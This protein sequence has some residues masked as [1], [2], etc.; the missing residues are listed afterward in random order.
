MQE[1][2]ITYKF[3]FYRLEFTNLKENNVECALLTGKVYNSSSEFHFKKYLS[4]LKN[5][6]WK[7]QRLV[8][9]RK[10]P[11]SFDSIEFIQQLVDKAAPLL[12][13]INM[14]PGEQ[15]ETGARLTINQKI[16]P[17]DKKDDVAVS[18][19]SQILG[20]PSP[21]WDEIWPLI[22]N[23]VNHD[24]H[25]TVQGFTNE[26]II[27]AIEQLELVFPS[28]WVKKQFKLE[29]KKHN[30]VLSMGMDFPPESDFWY[31]AYHIGRTALGAICI[32]PG[33]NFLVE[34][35]L[36]INDLK[37]VSGIEKIKDSL[38]K[39]SGNQHCV[40]LANDLNQRGLL[41]ELEPLIGN[42]PYKNDIT[43]D[44]NS[45]IIDIESKAFT[46]NNPDK[47]LAKEINKKIECL[48]N[49]YDRTLVFYAVLI[50]NGVFDKEKEIVF[51]KSISKLPEL[52]D[53]ITAVIGGKLFVDASGGHLKRDSEEIFVNQN[54]K[55]PLSEE[56]L[57]D[58]FKK[59][60]SDINYPIYGIGSYFYFSNETKN[61]NP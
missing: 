36:A 15:T 42:G 17:E 14:W 23:R 13:P 47:S 38:T 44:Y 29:A 40:C 33:W 10:P 35:G 28:S 16:A 22:V 25:F 34:L 49:N 61:D 39:Y 53:K 9:N 19:R 5:G 7:L 8:W 57:R 50:E 24:E 58:I 37:E 21:P 4:L 48:P 27:R 52:S 60:Y 54:A 30:A 45:K 26:E 12:Y 32:D 46:S 2:K 56:E 31:P 41:I 51:Y 55:H 6:E 3:E 11:S 20:I 18:F 59:N 1:R 43:I